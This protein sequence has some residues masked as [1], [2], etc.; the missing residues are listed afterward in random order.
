M[1]KTKVIHLSDPHNFYHQYLYNED[2]DVVVVTGD[3][4][5][6]TQEDFG[7]FLKWFADYPVEHKIYVAGNHDIFIERREKLCKV[8]VT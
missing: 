7:K 6:H 8:L 4:E 2:V 1:K 3:A 5:C